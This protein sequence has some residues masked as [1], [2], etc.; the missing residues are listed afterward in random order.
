MFKMGYIKNF[1]KE[2]SLACSKICNLVENPD[3]KE[4]SLRDYKIIVLAI[5]KLFYE[6]MT[7]ATINVEESKKSDKDFGF[8]YQGKYYLK[9]KSEVK[10]INQNFIMLYENKKFYDMSSS[11]KRS[12]ALGKP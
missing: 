3:S 8:F 12:S 7:L 11:Q 9:G 10:A 1:S 5:N 6:W 4:I 2:E